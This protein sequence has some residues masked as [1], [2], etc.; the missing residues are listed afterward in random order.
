MAFLTR[1]VDL[2]G[3]SLSE[4][5]RHKINRFVAD[6]TAENWDAIYAIV[7]SNVPRL[8][9]VW[10]AVTLLDKTF[11]RS[12]SSQDPWPRIPDGFLVARAIRNAT[13]GEP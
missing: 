4:E 5:N 13:Q 11:P 7:I 9:T 2:L 10:Q 6:P 12:K 8:R 1:A 3:H